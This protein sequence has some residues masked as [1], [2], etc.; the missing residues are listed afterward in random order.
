M[1]IILFTRH[2]LD[3]GLSRDDERIRHIRQVLKC[4]PGDWFDAGI[5]DGPRGK[6]RIV[7]IEDGGVTFEYELGREPPD[8]YPITLIIGMARPQTARRLLRELTSLGVERM[9]FAITDRSEKGYGKSKLWT[10][11][12]FR[13][14][15][16][17]GAEQ[18]FSTRLPDVQ[19]FESLDDALKRIGSERR[20]GDHAKAALDNYEAT[21]R[22]SEWNVVEKRMALVI[23]AERGWSGRERD[24]LRSSGFVLVGLGGRVLRVETAAVAAVTILLQKLGVM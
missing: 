1:N 5:P 24:L 13:R 20:E 11:G 3:T 2:E 17:Q 18:A 10:S 23:G 14:H 6:A 12:E 21:C 15:M 19:R 4:G 22:L 9:W 16:R 8:L 7:S